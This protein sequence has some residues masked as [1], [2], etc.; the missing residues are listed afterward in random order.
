MMIFGATFLSVL[1]VGVEMRAIARKRITL[2]AMAACVI[3]AGQIVALKLV[4]SSASWVDG[5]S[6]VLA[7]AL[8]ILASF[9]VYASAS[10]ENAQFQRPF[11][12]CQGR[13]E[14]FVIEGAGCPS[15]GGRST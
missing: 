2:A 10:A 4:P 11:D 13:T 14:C 15:G 9:Q 6:Y 5:A 3:A 1:A 12:G 7:N 8:G